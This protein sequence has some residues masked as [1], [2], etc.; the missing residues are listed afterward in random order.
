VPHPAPANARPA[1][2][3]VPTGVHRGPEQELPTSHPSRFQPQWLRLVLLIVPFPLPAL[4]RLFVPEDQRQSRKRE[5]EASLEPANT[6]KPLVCI[7]NSSLPHAHPASSWAVPVVV[8]V[9]G[10]ELPLTQTCN[11][12]GHRWICYCRASRRTHT[13]KTQQTDA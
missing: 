13:S 9:S 3:P 8:E 10:S 11:F 7:S 5:R 1:R 2:L 6:P 12:A 4:L